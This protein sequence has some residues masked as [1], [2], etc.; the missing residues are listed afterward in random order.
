MG[1]AYYLRCF[2]FGGC[3]H[4]HPAAAANRQGA[5]HH[6]PKKTTSQLQSTASSASSS[7]GL[8]FREEY[9]SAFRTESYNDF[10]ARVLDI[11]LAHGAALVPRP[12][13]AA[14]AASKRL[15]SY[16]V[17]AE[18]LLDPDQAAAAAALASARN[19][20]DVHGL[21]SAY[22]DETAGASFL[23]SHL[24]KDIEQIRLRYRPLKAALRGRLVPGGSLA[25]VSAALGKPFTALAATQG[26]LGDARLSSADLLKGLDSGRKAARR[27]IR[28]LARL[29]QAL[30]VSFVTVVAVVAVVGACVGVHVLA[31]FAA[32][33][34]MSP[35]WLGLFSGRGARRALVQLEAAAKGT[36][37]LNR[38]M[39]TI[40]RLVERVRDEGEYMLALLQLCVAEEAAAGAGAGKGRLVREVLRQLC[41]NE[42]SFRQQLD[43]LEEHLFLCFMTIN[44]ARSMVIKFM[45]TAA[46]R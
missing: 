26:R 33:P 28:T 37:I 16:R 23:C 22:Y 12:A 4:P 11:T 27:R 8:D 17:F 15:S 29:R 18:H 3:V 1:A 31:A 44:K 25:D 38:D 32:F 41:K 34:M 19:R 42:E 2:G 39:D 36:Y 20:P 14:S 35:A 24:L 30:S 45:A 13:S 46:S 21:L 6:D 10:W 7:S 43:E 40:S 9:T 5:R